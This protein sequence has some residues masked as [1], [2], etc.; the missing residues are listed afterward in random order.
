MG[1]ALYDS[2][3]QRRVSSCPCAPLLFMAEHLAAQPRRPSSGWATSLRLRARLERQVLRCVVAVAAVAACLGGCSVSGS[4]VV[5]GSALNLRQESKYDALW[6]ADW[7]TIAIDQRPLQASA[8]SPGACNTGGSKKGCYD[9]DV[10]LIADFR[11]LGSDLSG[12]VVP[13]EFARAN[14]TLHRCIVDDIRGL[15]DRDAA[16]ASQNPHATFSQ[17]N[18]EL[19][20]GQRTCEQALSE[21]HGVKLPPNPFN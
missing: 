15:S 17:S 16:I 12:S 4:V 6:S 19:E 20:L 21:Y 13:S 18:K 14:A 3:S 11:K 5:S 7:R 2:S 10:R 8:S 9:G 1:Y